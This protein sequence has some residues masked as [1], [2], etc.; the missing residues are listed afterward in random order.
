MA[1]YGGRLV[2]TA[3]GAEYIA[4]LTVADAAARDA[5]VAAGSAQVGAII[6]LRD[7]ADAGRRFRVIDTAPTYEEISRYSAAVAPAVRDLYVNHSTGSDSNAGDQAAPLATIQEAVNRF[8][9]PAL[10]VQ[11]WELGDDRTIY[12]AD[13]GGPNSKFQESILICLLY[14]SDAADE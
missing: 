9:Q 13:P 6:R 14:T 2:N 10:G 11:T 12:V 1:N 8:K 3:V 4:E 7:G 5:A